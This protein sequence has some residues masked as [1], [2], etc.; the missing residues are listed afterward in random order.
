MFRTDQTTAVTAIPA[1]SAAGTPGYFT[2]GNPATGQ[3]ATILD[4]DWLN[5]VQE[6][7]MNVVTA[8]GLTPSKTVY[9]QLLSAIRALRGTSQ[10]LADTGAANAYAAANATP[11]AAAPTVSGVTQEFRVA[12][13]NTGASTYKPDAL[14]AAPIFGMGAAALQG[15]ELVTNGVATLV[16]FVSPLLNGG[17]LCWILV[18]CTGGAVQVADGSQSGHAVSLGQL[19]TG[20]TMQAIANAAG[21]SLTASYIKL[22]SWLGGLIIQ[23]G[24]ISV[25]TADTPLVFPVA[26]TQGV[27]F[28]SAFPTYT[29]NGAF[30]VYNS[31]TFSGMNLATWATN[32]TRVAAVCYWLAIGK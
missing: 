3:A 22:P 26:F 6:E 8:A 14:P 24:Q 31:L 16:S 29:N 19:L 15:G 7:L 4:A 12:N 21:F 18:K 23:W 9:T 30:A 2:G 11:L 17:A 5:M 20:S 27:D 32:S 1:P 25:G 10:V 13:T 28:I